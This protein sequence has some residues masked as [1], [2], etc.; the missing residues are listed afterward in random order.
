MRRRSPRSFKPARLPQIFHQSIRVIS[1]RRL[2]TYTLQTPCG[3]VKLRRPPSSR[4][5]LKRCG[6]EQTKQTQATEAAV[7]HKCPLK[8]TRGHF[9]RPVHCLINVQPGFST[10]FIKALC[11]C[12]NTTNRYSCGEVVVVVVAGQS[13][14]PLILIM[15]PSSHV[16]P[17][18]NS[19]GFKS[20]LLSP[21]YF[22]SRREDGTG[23]VIITLCVI[24]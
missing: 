19:N 14:P 24:S 6:R 12:V 17:T 13:I 10:P 23:M 8:Y 9:H 15:K 22:F 16:F 20:H 21:H 18:G 7:Q 11:K 4:R 2:V 3:S 1:R 5:V